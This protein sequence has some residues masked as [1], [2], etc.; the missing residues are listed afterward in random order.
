ME[1]F[2][3]LLRAVQLRWEPSRAASFQSSVVSQQSLLGQVPLAWPA[4]DGYPDADERW[5][6]AGAMVARW[7]LAAQASNGFGASAPQFDPT[8]IFGSSPPATV[9]EA[10]DRAASA[11]LG[12]PL[13]PSVRS[14]I[15]SASGLSATT[16]WRSSSARAVI[17]HVLQ[18]PQNQV[19]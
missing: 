4:P 15:L 11:L 18:S 1:W 3:S 16:P 14:A 2:A 12:E 6:S 19:R 13:T 10:I 5:C 8:R 9:G 7:N 17:A